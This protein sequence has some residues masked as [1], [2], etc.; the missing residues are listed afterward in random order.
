MKGKE[1]GVAVLVGSSGNLAPIWKEG[2][3][4]NGYIIYEIDPSHYHDVRKLETIEHARMECLCNCGIPEIILYNAAIDNPPSAP[5]KFFGNF[6]EITAV[7]LCGVANVAK[8]FIPDMIKA[9]GG[10]FITVGSIM[11]NIGADW[12]NYGENFEKP[13]AYNTSKAALVQ[14]SRSLT[15]QFGR[16]NIRAVTIASGAYDAGQLTD[17]FKAKFLR[18]VPLGRTISK[19]S[20]KAALTMCINAPEFTGQQLLI[21]GGYT[22]W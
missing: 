18:N 8:T 15:S 19:E 12:R 9:G 3:E 17:D 16:Y 6:E 20:Y 13:V 4:E 21:D 5:A 22:I 2:L 1:K 14:L 7:N 10:L 11:G